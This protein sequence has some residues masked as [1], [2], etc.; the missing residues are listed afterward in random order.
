MNEI[1]YVEASRKLG[2]RMLTQGGQTDAERIANGLQWVLA[3]P[4]KPAEVAVLVAGLTADRKLFEQRPD[5][6]KQFLTVGA[7]PVPL[8][9]NQAELA[10]Y[11]LTAN[12]LLNL[13][14]AVTRE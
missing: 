8:N 5:D 1:T 7:S 6:A 13:D 3:R 12:V 2:E 4:A 10:A 11:A 9:L 14:E